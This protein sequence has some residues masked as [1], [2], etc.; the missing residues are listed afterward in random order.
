MRALSD[1]E[2]AETEAVLRNRLAQLADHAPTTVQLPG[3]V[4]VVAFGSRTRNRRRV[5]VIATVTALIG[6]G[7]FTTYSFLATGDDGGAA[8]P[9]EAVTT[10]VSAVEHEDVLGMIDV[11]LPEEVAVLRNAVESITADA[12]RIDVLGASFDA[13][14]VQGIDISVDDLT[15]ATD[16][17]EG[18]LATVSAT[19]GTV[20]ASFDPLAFPFGAKVRAL[21]GDAQL[22]GSASA[23]IGGTE[24]PALLMTVQRGGRWYVSVEYTVAEYVRRSAGW[25]LPGPVTRSPIGFDSPEGAVNAFYDRL[26]ALD[27]QGALDSFAP[28]EDAMAWLAQSWMP[29]AAAAIERGRADGWSVAISGLT[30]ETIGDGSHR[31]LEPLTYRVEATVPAAFND[32][33]SGYSDPSKPT[34]VWAFDS[35]G[36]AIA[37][38]GQVPATTAGLSFNPGPPP[39]DNGGDNFTSTNP[40][41]T[42]NPLVF[43]PE[44]S[45]G[46]KHLTI[47]HADGCSTYTGDAAQTTFGLV[48]SPMVKSVDGGFQMCG[49]GLFGGLS[50]LLLAGGLTELPAV[51]VVESGGQWYVSPLGT[52]LASI[53][54]S[55][56][57]TKDGASLFDSALAPFLY[58]GM[59]RSSLETM[60]VGQAVDSI[61]AECLPALTVDNGAVTGFVADPA[62]DAVRACLATAG[63]ESST[64]SSGSGVAPP[65]KVTV[66]PATTP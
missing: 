63:F 1:Q 23:S 15:L 19:G 3:E 18:G 9:E 27:P 5:G 47:D 60:I 29:A 62:L 2:F 66:V 37:P 30:Y 24:P 12:K 50:V 11:T 8:T 40:D 14:G 58:G 28:G 10:F 48:E 26:A 33:A 31:T 32:G 61:A 43:A 56:H 65:V 6:A 25:E 34:I 41:G 7:S 36:Y 16:Y 59:S 44:S 55:L 51:S 45:A 49:P 38:P 22:G 64:S 21:L 13:G 54:T 35:S 46:P 17:L 52:A 39:L 42:I 20:S 4:P 57:D 53:S